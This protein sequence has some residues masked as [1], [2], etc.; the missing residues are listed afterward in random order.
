MT[1]K[2]NTEDAIADEM[3]VVGFLSPK[4]DAH[5]SFI[6]QDHAAWFDVCSRINKLA[7]SAWIN[8]PIE[9]AGQDPND[10]EPLAV[11]LMA[12]AIS[13]YEAAILVLQLG[14]TV[15]GGTLA[16]S[17]YET[18]FWIAF[19]MKN[20]PEAVRWFNLDDD[21]GRHG[22]LKAFANLYA[23]NKE[24]LPGIKADLLKAAKKV[25]GQPRPLG[26][27][28]LA[29]R[30]TVDNY[31]AYYKRLC[32]SSAH[33]SVMSTDHYLT[34]FDDGTAGHELGPDMAGIDRMLAFCGHAMIMCIT[35]FSVT[36][37]DLQTQSAIVKLNEEFLQMSQ[38]FALGN[39]E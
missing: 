30:G 7:V 24:L 36:V 34:F 35:T 2:R 12:R 33:A 9:T 31:Y 37:R 38:Q 13:G 32:G 21:H 26:M 29:K 25:E 14:M 15:E 6:V 27:E 5:R 18:G 16:R 3:S 23:N 28:T 22:R 17:V 8:H 20:A 11:R 10:P 1:M 19:I 39:F 4:L